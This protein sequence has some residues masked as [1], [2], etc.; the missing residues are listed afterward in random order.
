MFNDDKH[1]VDISILSSGVYSV[2][3]H[4]EAGKTSQLLI[5]Q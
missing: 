4:N 3:L 2:L 1:S 5:K